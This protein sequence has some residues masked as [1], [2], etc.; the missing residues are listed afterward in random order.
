MNFLLNKDTEKASENLETLE[1]SKSSEID[2]R[3]TISAT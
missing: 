2:K 1:T 3:P